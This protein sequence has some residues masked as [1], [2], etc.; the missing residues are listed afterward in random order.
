MATV[1]EDLNQVEKDI[2]QLKIEFEQ[3][4][5]GG[6]KRPP[7][8]IVWRIEQMLKRYGEKGGQL[9]FSQRF[10]LNNLT[11]SFAK[12]ND[13]FRK[14][15]KAKEEGTVQRHFGAAAREIQAQRERERPTPPPEPEPT[16]RRA[17]AGRGG[18]TVVACSDPAKEGAKVKQL[19]DAL[20]E[21]KKKA[22]EKTDSL[23]LESFTKFV[24]GKTDQLKG[25]KGSKEVEFAVSVESGQVKLK[26]RVK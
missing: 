5:G 15:M 9:N 6:R 3:Y 25:Q 18:E 8:E 26:A 21:A 22:G 14:K 23:T 16:A 20:I 11:S 10:R 4:F 7:T 24:S 19:Y 13:M 17:A 1:D 2:R 12:Y